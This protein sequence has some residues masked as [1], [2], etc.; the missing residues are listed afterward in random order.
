M[1]RLDHERQCIL[2][3]IG[4]DASGRKELLALEDGYRESAQSWRE[5]LLRL[6]DENGLAAPPAL[7]T[8]DGALGFWKALHEVW[9]TTRQQRCPPGSLDPGRSAGGSQAMGPQDRQRPQP[10]AEVGARQG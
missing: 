6:R 4:A 1:P 7:A 8:G 3:L 5:L 9:P 10:P 2:V